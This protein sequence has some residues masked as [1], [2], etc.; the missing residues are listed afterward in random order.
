[1]RTVNH[2]DGI[3]YEINTGKPFTG[4]LL[5]KHKNGLKKVEENYGNGKRHGVKTWWH[6][7]GQK[8]SEIN[9]ENGK[10]HGVKTWW[11][12]NGQK[13]FEINYENEQ[14]IFKINY[15]DG[16][17]HMLAIQWAYIRCL[18]VLRGRRAWFP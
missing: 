10:R 9:Y 1:M 7:N 11:H 8:R 18:L 13:R 17:G 16:K 6:E 2:K 14:K 4:K 5:K 15:K 3:A 12:E